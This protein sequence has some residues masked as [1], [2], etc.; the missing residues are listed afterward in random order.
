MKRPQK[1]C[2][3]PAELDEADD[4]RPLRTSIW[5]LHC[6]RTKRR[7]DDGPSDEDI[8]AELYG[9]EPDQIYDEI[10]ARSR[11]RRRV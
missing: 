3:S 9:L 4:V 11:R 8:V 6:G 7:V 1:C 10:K 5:R 2:G